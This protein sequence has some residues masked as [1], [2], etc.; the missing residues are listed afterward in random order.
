[1][2][3]IKHHGEEDKLEKT[4]GILVDEVVEIISA[5]KSENNYLL[6]FTPSNDN[7][8]CE[9]CYN[10]GRKKNTSPQLF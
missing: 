3:I 6:Q 2:L 7:S 10:L 8:F 9:W 1:M 5:D 4:F